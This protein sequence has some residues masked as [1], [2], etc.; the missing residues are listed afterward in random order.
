MSRVIRTASITDPAPA[1]VNASTTTPASFGELLDMNGSRDTLYFRK[2][3]SEEAV[4]GYSADQGA[5]IA[6]GKNFGGGSRRLRGVL[7]LPSGEMIVSTQEKSDAGPGYLVRSQGFNRVVAKALSS[8]VVTLTTA[9]PHGLTVGQQVEVSGMGSPFDTGTATV[10]STPT[11]TT[12]TFSKSGSNVTEAAATGMIGKWTTVLTC[13]GNAAFI[14]GRWGF[15]RQCIMP[16][17]SS[18]PGWVLAV[19]YGRKFSEALSA[20][21]TTQQSA[22]RA[23]LSKDD[24]LTWTTIFNLND[25]YPAADAQ[26]HMHGGCFD[27]WDDR[28]YLTYGDGGFSDGGE[29]AIAYCNLEDIDN[30]VWHDVQGTRG[31]N[32]RQA[33]VTTIVPTPSALL[34]LSDAEVGC[35]ARF[36]RRGWRNLGPRTEAAPLP[37]GAIGSHIYAPDIPGAPVLITYQSTTP[38]GEHPPFALALFADGSV[39]EVYR[40]ASNVNSTSRGLIG[41]VG[42]DLYGRVYGNIQLAGTTYLLSGDWTPPT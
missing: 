2:S 21:G 16:P 34:A 12:F 33:Q 40:A 24:G 39:S 38:S 28:I 41:L 32:P 8:N 42:P 30:P 18:R 25:R 3:G 22:C 11:A 26:L 37:A 13:S 19:E 35:V 4:L 15:N 17:W 7:E 9:E 10:A 31:T 20:G 29:C 5:T 1:L 23:Y 27:P 36:G 6:W 14:E